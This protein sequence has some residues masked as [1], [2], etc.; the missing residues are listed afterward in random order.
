MALGDKR[1]FMLPGPPGECLPMVKKVVLPAL[2]QADFHTIRFRQ[3]WLL[4]GVSEGKIAERLDTLIAGSR[5]TTAI[6]W[7]TLMW[8]QADLPA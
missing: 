8:N 6:V 3:S 1:I 7:P 2:E 5:C 4:F